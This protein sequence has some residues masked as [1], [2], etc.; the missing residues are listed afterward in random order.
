MVCWKCLDSKVALEYDGNKLNKVCKACYS[1]L[2]GQREERVEE[3]KRR[4]LE[5]SLKCF[6]KVKARLSFFF[7]LRDLNTTYHGCT[8]LP[9]LCFLVCVFSQSEAS[10]VSSD[11]VMSGF[12]LYGDNPKTWQQVWTVISR[13]EP[14][15][16]HLYTAP[17]VGISVIKNNVNAAV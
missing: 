16:L 1:T 13:T 6:L 17:Q 9:A 7:F 14:P 15:A 10:P 5:V 2:T 11:C 8:S 4:I 3:N 12:L